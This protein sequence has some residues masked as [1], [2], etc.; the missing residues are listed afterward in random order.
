MTTYEVRIADALGT[1]LAAVRDFTTDPDKGGAMC[2]YA[3]NVGQ[4]G[5]LTLTLPPQYDKALLL[6]GRISVFRDVGGGGKREGDAQFLIRKWVYG[7]QTTTVTAYHVNDLLRRRIINYF[8]GTTYTSKTSTA[9]DNLIKAFITQQ[10]GAGIVG[11]DRIGVETYADISAYLSL[12]ASTGLGPT[13][14]LAAAWQ[15]LFDVVR[16]LADAATQAGT[17]LTAD[18]VATSDS[19]LELR[20]YVGQRGVDRRASGTQGLIFASTLGNVENVAL[21]VDR[22]NE[23][24]FATAAGV[25]QGTARMTQ[26]AS[27]DARMAE[28]PFNRREVFVDQSNV[29]DTAQL[30][31][32]A[33][34]AVRAGRPA[35]SLTG[36]I[37]E[38]PFCV[39]G[40]HYDLGDYVTVQHRG[41]QY[42]VRLDTIAVQ[43]GRGTVQQKVEFKY[44]P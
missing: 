9:A 28:S 21:T 31:A 40:L 4:V 38:T 29:T 5:A 36:D 15:N 22:T 44:N 43:L 32:Y 6:D 12:Q 16:K 17:Y 30:L 23:V 1:Q 24:T 25:G 8:S 19:A 33:R 27:D 3:L 7:E 37:V 39:R 35:I 13:T 14:S 20:T 18:V 2:A 26:T 10:L 11:A 41:Q 34:A 42:D